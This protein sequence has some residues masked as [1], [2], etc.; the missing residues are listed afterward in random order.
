MPVV[1]AHVEGRTCDTVA[2]MNSTMG[3]SEHTA[4][5]MFSRDSSANL[6]MCEPVNRMRSAT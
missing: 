4:T 1:S 3:T 5:A 6:H 2:P